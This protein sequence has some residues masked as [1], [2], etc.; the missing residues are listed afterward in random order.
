MRDSERFLAD[1]GVDFRLVAAL[2]ELG[3]DV[4]S[5]AEER[6]AISDEEV[7]EIAIKTE[8]ILLTEDKDFGE[9]VFR[10]NLTVTGV[11]LI[12]LHGLIA[13]EKVRAVQVA[14]ELH[15]QEF[16]GAFSVLTDKALRIRKF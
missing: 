3:Y 8:S 6:P 1:E 10:Q 4:A 9:M 7:L 13:R 2:R 16:Y 15:A 12:R 5:I 11:L 14:F